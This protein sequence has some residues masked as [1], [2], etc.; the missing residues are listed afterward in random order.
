MSEL[1]AFLFRVEVWSF[2]DDH[3]DELMAVVKNV[4]VARAAYEAAL[5]ER[6]DRIVRLRNK[7]MVLAERFP[8]KRTRGCAVLRDIRQVHLTATAIIEGCDSHGRQN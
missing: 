8:M 1:D 4:M 5:Q 7:A 2:N 3:V 6:P